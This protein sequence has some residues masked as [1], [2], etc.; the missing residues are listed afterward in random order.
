M[1]LRSCAQ[2]AGANV[3]IGD[4][5]SFDLFI[6][7]FEAGRSLGAG[8]KTFE[9]VFGLHSTA[10][11]DKFSRLSFSDGGGADAY[12]GESGAYMFNHF[13][14]EEFFEHLFCFLR[15]SRGIAYWPGEGCSAAVADES[16]LGELPGAMVAALNPTVVMSAAELMH[17]II[18]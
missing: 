12:F 10:V 5:V 1:T 13:G 7:R 17:V 2:R 11:D 18:S 14:G 6:D 8:A 3:L 4:G 16:V 15:E 9:R